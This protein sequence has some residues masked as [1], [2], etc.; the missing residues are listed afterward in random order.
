[1]LGVQTPSFTA[2]VRLGAELLRHWHDVGAD[3]CG[4]AYLSSPCDGEVNLRFLLTAFEDTTT[5]CAVFK[6]DGAHK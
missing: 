3:W 6:N 2:A 5:K 1:M 4:P